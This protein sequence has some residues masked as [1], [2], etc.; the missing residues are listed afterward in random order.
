VD[1]DHYGT[2]R[3]SFVDDWHTNIAKVWCASSISDGIRG[4][5]MTYGNFR[6]RQYS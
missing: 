6:F 2:G 4:G 1:C 3:N 5:R